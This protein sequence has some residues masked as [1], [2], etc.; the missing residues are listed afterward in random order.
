M[1]WSVYRTAC[2]A[3]LGF[4]TAGVWF[5]TCLYVTPHL[6]LKFS[7]QMNCDTCCRRQPGS[8]GHACGNRSVWSSYSTTNIPFWPGA[9]MMRLRYC[10]RSACESYGT[11]T[12]L[13][14][15]G[16]HMAGLDVPP[17][18]LCCTAGSEREGASQQKP[19]KPA[20][21]ELRTLKAQNEE[22]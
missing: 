2:R 21:A 5:G 4:V 7:D 18:Q 22:H 9:L 16:M 14:S 10:K 19:A 20:S 3:C 8:I 15:D 1:L 6:S 11:L 12:E 17:I 13:N